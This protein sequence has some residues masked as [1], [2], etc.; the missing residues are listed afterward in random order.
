MNSI[1]ENLANSAMGTVP[2]AILCVRNVDHLKKIMSSDSSAESLAKA[3]DNMSNTLNVSE[4]LDSALMDRTRGALSGTLSSADKNALM[5]AGKEYLALEVQYNP[6][7]IHM[8]TVTGSQLDYC[9]GSMGNKANN[10]IVQ[11]TVPTSTTMTVQLI[12]D[13][14]N[15][16]DAFMVNNINSP[17]GATAQAVKYF[18][19]GKHTVQPQVEGILSLLTMD[20]TRQV[21]FYWAKMSFRGELTGV[22]ARY[23]MFN[24]SGDPIRAVVSL[25]IRQGEQEMLYDSG[26][27]E[28]AYENL[29]EKGKHNGQGILAKATN[30]NILNLNL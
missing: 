25:S 26:Y 2:K 18:V 6:S 23:T 15:M 22:Q 16:F 14:V 5:G 28:K 20:A 3:K 30:N 13:D 10:M 29:F 24:K 21:I 19:S 12:F 8:Q 4:A 1:V 9:G 7:S 27:W 17:V 11:N